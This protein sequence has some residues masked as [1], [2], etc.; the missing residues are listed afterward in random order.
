MTGC[1]LV[2][3]ADATPEI[4]AGHLM[5]CISFA[6]GWM[7]EG[8]GQAAVWGTVS[9]PFVKARLSEC[10]IPLIKSPP[11]DAISV[12]I[13]DSYDEGIR[14]SAPSATRARVR[15]LV[16][17]LGDLAE[18]YNVIWNPN[19]YSTDGLYAGFEGRVISGEK[20]IPIR[21]GLPKWTP[22]SSAVAVSLG[23]TCPPDWLV[24]ALRIWGSSLG[25]LPVTGES[26]WVPAG[27][28]TVPADRAWSA[29][30]KRSMLLSSA[31][32]TVW[33]AANVGIPLCLIVTAPNQR[34]AAQWAVGRGVPQMDALRERDP[35]GF[36]ASLFGAVAAASA[37]P[38]LESGVRAAA[39]A[40]RQLAAER[41]Y[42]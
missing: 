28:K 13:V 14:L 40:I 39:R 23:G 15:V 18:G 9:I 31:G 17:D 42:Q 25:E 6:Q 16:D 8:L 38:H 35:A 32:S 5:R 26:L 1:P 3:R 41:E 22:E 27:W 34:L 20:T 30:A 10:R 21:S 37:L 29:F 11:S 12:L 4:G 24:E 36:A 33:E 19:A 2:V 7:A